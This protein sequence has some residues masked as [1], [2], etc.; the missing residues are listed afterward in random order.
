MRTQL[1][2]TRQN[3]FV[4]AFFVLLIGLLSLLFTLLEPFLR[5]FVWSMIL[6]MVFYPVHARLLRLTG[7]RPSLAAFL[8]SV[9][10]VIFLT[11]MGCSSAKDKVEIPKSG[12]QPAPKMDKK[13]D[14]KT[15][16]V[17]RQD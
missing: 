1:K 7:G 3:V 6:V 2:I 10:V 17:E 8:S 16:P 15:S 9:I 4:V 13:M 12:G 11:V 5:A 14:P